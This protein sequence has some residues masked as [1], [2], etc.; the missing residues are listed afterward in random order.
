MTV[1]TEVKY[2]NERDVYN[3]DQQF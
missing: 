1:K 3:L 2:L